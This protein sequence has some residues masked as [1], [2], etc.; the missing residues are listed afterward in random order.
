VLRIPHAGSAACAAPT[1][2]PILPTCASTASAHKWTLQRASKSRSPCCGARSAV[3]T[4]SR[5]STGCV[6][7]WRARSCS[8]S[9]S[10]K[11]RD[12]TRCLHGCPHGL[13]ACRMGQPTHAA[14]AAAVVQGCAS[15]CCHPIIP[16]RQPLAH[17]AALHL[18]KHGPRPRLPAARTRGRC[19]TVLPA[20][21][22][23]SVVCRQDV[24]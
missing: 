11:L 23:P 16:R 22:A 24:V 10:R 8:L 6:Q 12:S 21:T 14:C 20:C 19:R 7:S 17:P 9:A 18:P 4:C 3:A 13:H 15:M 5:P 1:S 2:S